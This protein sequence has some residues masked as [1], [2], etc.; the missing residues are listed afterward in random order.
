ML[1]EKTITAQNTFTDWKL[2]S[3]YQTVDISISGLSATTVTLQRK[4]KKYGA[5]VLDV[6]TW[7]ADEETYFTVP[8]DAYYRVGVKTGGY[9]GGDTVKVK[10]SI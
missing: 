4:F 2:F 5:D 9:G 10:L 7:T 8:S 6:E 1:L 3:A